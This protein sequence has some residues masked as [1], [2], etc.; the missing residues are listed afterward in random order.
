MIINRLAREEKHML[1]QAMIEFKGEPKGFVIGNNNA[2]RTNKILDAIAE[3]FNFTKSNLKQTPV[4]GDNDK[5]G[6]VNTAFYENEETV[7]ATPDQTRKPD[8]GHRLIVISGNAPADKTYHLDRSK[9]MIGRDK[10]SHIRIDDKSVSLYHS[11][12]CMKAKECFL[13]DLNSKNGTL[14]NGHRVLDSQ[15]LH[16]GDKIGIGSTLFT[17][18]HGDLSRSRGTRKLFRNKHFIPGALVFSVALIM[19][20]FICINQIKAGV[21]QEASSLEHNASNAHLAPGE[22]DMSPLAKTSMAQQEVAPGP[23]RPVAPEEKGRQLIQSALNQYINGNIALAYQM[24]EETLH[25][26]LSENS[27]LRS[28]AL[29]IKGRIVMIDNLYNKGFKHYEEN[30]MRQAIA[31]WAQTLKADQDLAGQTTSF[32]AGRIAV[33]TA[34]IL[35]RMARQALENGNNVKAQELCSQTFR[36]QEDHEG[37]TAIMQSLSRDSKQ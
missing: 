13:K 3:I 18:I 33:H 23:V 35:F 9:M 25:L 11:M 34:D 24:L 32:F 19:S 26:N 7:F 8:N 29:A 5:E 36:V 17:F 20:V 27:A 31:I 16:D 10:G 21:P 15:K 6:S 37:C 14:V 30:N 28:N 4:F 12:I 2:D 22:R 1:Q